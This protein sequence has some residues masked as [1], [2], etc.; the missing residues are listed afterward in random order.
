[1]E[2]KIIMEQNGNSQEITK[3]KL[4]E[5]ASNPDYSVETKKETDEEINVNVKQ[6]LYD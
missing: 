4:D 1:M 6:R 3:S 2:K 5:L